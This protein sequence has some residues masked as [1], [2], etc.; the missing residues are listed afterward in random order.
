MTMATRKAAAAPTAA[1]SDEGGATGD[2]AG[3][4]IDRVP[5]RR[6]AVVSVAITV[7]ILKVLVAANTAGTSDV[8]AWEFFA[9]QVREAGPVGIYG[10]DVSPAIYNHPPLAGHLLVLINWLIDHG[11]GAFPLLIRTPATLADVVT[12]VLIFEL[13]R[14]WRPRNEATAAGVLVA[15]SPVLFVVS[16]FHGNT[17]PVFVM[18]A[19]LSAYLL[20][21][22]TSAALAG[23]SIAVALSVKLV[24]IVVLP[25]LILVA[26]RW[27]WRRL[28]A[29]LATAGAFLLIVW[30]PV[31]LFQ[32]SG[33]RESVLGY[34]GISQREWGLVQ[35]ARWL[36]LPEAW[37]DLL[38]G[39][40][41]F[42][43]LLLSAGLPVVLLWRRSYR[44]GTAIG[45]A[46]ALFLLMS[47][48]FGV[49]YLAWPVAAAYL[50][51]FWLATAYNLTA[52][53]LLVLVYDHWNGA[54]P[55]NWDFAIYHPFRPR[56]HVLAVLTWLV[57][58]R[59]AVA[60]ALLISAG[61][62]GGP[63]KHARQRRAA[64]SPF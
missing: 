34:A 31:A 54:L 24:P 11:I 7:A 29:F 57:L 44:A 47:P 46:L 36:Q 56:E 30:G 3:W 13:V 20:I 10:V 17:D 42:V 14:R 49:Q 2:D 53:A 25:V 6:L 19:L 35:F 64:R 63:G 16:G 39:P 58:A 40:G 26:L 38:V 18:F 52:G 59:I 43:V 5:R 23:L 55:W 22:R 50:I 28:V 61:P 41:R 32:W 48:A 27:D 37:V 4:T 51:N 12:A 60:G 45:L 9:Q 1:A 33:F 62:G 21:S 15:C 8:R